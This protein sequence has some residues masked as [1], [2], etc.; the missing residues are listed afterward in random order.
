[1]L[2]KKRPGFI[3]APSLNTHNGT[4][5]PRQ[6]RGIHLCAFADYA[7]WRTSSDRF[8]QCVFA[9]TWNG[10]VLYLFTKYE[11][12]RGVYSPITRNGTKHISWIRK[13]ILN[14]NMSAN[15]KPKSKM[16]LVG[17][18]ESRWVNL[19]KSAY[20]KNFMQVYLQEGIIYVYIC[21]SYLT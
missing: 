13:N 18:Q 11:V 4:V 17:N 6:T 7:E 5:S 19:P 8:S 9:K 2:K 3:W 16:F 21:T 15:S 12:W 10:T 20:T 14:L 1:M